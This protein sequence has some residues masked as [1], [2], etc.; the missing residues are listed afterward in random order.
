M[1]S[2][3]DAYVRAYKAVI[4]DGYKSLVQYRKI[5]VSKESL[6]N[7]DLLTVIAIEWLVNADIIVSYV[8]KQIL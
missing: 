8:A 1:A 5:E 4:T 6:A 7:P 2:R 3:I